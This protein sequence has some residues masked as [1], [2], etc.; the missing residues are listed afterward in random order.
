MAG[1]LAV[2]FPG[3]GQLYNGQIILSVIILLAVFACHALIAIPKPNLPIP[4][5]LISVG[6]YLLA[7]GQALFK[8]HKLR[9]GFIAAKWNN[10]VFYMVALMF[11]IILTQLPGQVLYTFHQV[12]NECMAGVYETG[13]IVYVN[14]IATLFS[15]PR[16]EQIVVF[17]PVNNPNRVS[18]GR[19]WA[20]S[21]RPIEIRDNYIYMDGYRIITT[22][23]NPFELQTVGGDAADIVRRASVQDTVIPENNYLV[24]GDNSFGWADEVCT[25]II[26]RTNLVGRVDYTFFKSSGDETT[27]RESYRLLI[28]YLFFA[29]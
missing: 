25:G 20:Q 15:E 13:D 21:G 9:D 27:D 19:I 17:R 11:G 2:I 6:I 28:Y 7:I 3:L 12:D 24:I 29:L 8:T 1:L 18:V 14:K 16:E 5:L 23:T 4:L 26:P 10:W 22:G